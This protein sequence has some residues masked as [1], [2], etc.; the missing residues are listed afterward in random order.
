MSLRARIATRP[1]PEHTR[2][3]DRTAEGSTCW[4]ID[5]QHGA[6]L[7][8]F[9]MMALWV[10]PLIVRSVPTNSHRGHAQATHDACRIKWFGNMPVHVPFHTKLDHTPD[11]YQA[12]CPD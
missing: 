6:K 12:V 1:K 11:W 9:Q 7:R 5:G 8:L 10:C 2:W 3:N 4:G